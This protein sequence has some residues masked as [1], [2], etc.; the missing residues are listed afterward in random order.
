MEDEDD[1]IIFYEEEPNV[2]HLAGNCNGDELSNDWRTKH[3]QQHVLLSGFDE[4]AKHNNAIVVEITIHYN[5]R[6]AP[7]SS[8]TVNTR[9]IRA[10]RNEIDILTKLKNPHH[11]HMHRQS[12]FSF[13]SGRETYCSHIN[14]FEEG[15]DGCD[16]FTYY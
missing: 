8:V 16:C 5:N 12:W 10:L 1:L 9:D 6:R 7:Y 13:V 14:F 11:T 2:E 15:K 4:I 3:R